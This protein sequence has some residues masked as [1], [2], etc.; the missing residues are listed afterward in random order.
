MELIAV[1]AV[2]AIL[3]TFAIPAYR[4][5]LEHT[6]N[7]R[8]MTE[9]RI[10][11][12]EIYDYEGRFG[13]LPTNLAAIDRGTLN[14]PWGRSYIYSPTLTRIRFADLLNDDFDLYSMGTDGLT[15]AEVGGGGG[16]GKDDLVRGRGGAFLGLGENW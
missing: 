8:A 14:D 3:A 15:E 2:I 9:I 12:T 16:T 7:S 5:F 11:E 1:S 13:F 4:V 10:L 6:R